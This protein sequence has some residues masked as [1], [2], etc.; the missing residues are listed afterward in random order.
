MCSCSKAPLLVLEIFSALMS[1]DSLFHKFILAIQLEGMSLDIILYI[2]CRLLTY[3]FYTWVLPHTCAQAFTQ[4]LP[5][6]K[7]WGHSS[8][9]QANPPGTGL[10]RRT[11][12][13]SWREAAE[14]TVLQQ[15]QHN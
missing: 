11:V 14:P 13:V 3:L 7:P 10:N 8:L 15:L 9:V 5:L 4:L 6:S 2:Y 12:Q 1:T